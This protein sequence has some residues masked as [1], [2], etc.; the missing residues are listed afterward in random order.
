MDRVVNDDV[1]VALATRPGLQSLEFQKVITAELV[2]I[3]ES[4]QNQ[5]DGE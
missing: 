3:T 4:R 2:P 5:N 1:F